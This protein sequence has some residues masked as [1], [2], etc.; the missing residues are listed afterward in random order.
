[1]NTAVR[2]ASNL[3]TLFY[4]LGAFAK[5]AK[6]DC[7]LRHVCL[8]VCMEQLGSHWIDFHKI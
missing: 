8:Y 3:A 6:V 2:H 4:F 5:I 7:W 1:M